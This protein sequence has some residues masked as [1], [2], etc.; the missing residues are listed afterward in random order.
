MENPF[1]IIEQRLIAIE[2]KVDDLLQKFEQY[3]E[4]KHPPPIWMNS[5]ELSKYLGIT[6]AALAN[7]RTR[8]IPYYKIGGRIMYKKQ[9]IDEFI[10]RTRHKSGS[11]N[12]DEYLTS[13]EGRHRLSQ[14]R[15]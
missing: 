1:D 14:S 5:K 8:K 9:E 15:F 12:L 7:L 4:T 2:A 11:E 3:D 13:N 6:T 10:E